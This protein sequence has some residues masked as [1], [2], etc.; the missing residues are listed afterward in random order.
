MSIS[1][2]VV[3][4]APERA[5][6]VRNAMEMFDGVEIHKL[7]DNGQIIVTIDSPSGRSA[8]ETISKFNS[9]RGVLSTSLVYSYFEDDL[10]KG[11]HES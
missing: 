3:Q 2:L 1:S 9:I 6:D 7:T 10:A 5:V 11:E 8:A 4:V